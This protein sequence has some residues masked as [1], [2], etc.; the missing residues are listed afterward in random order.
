MSAPHLDH[1]S[2]TTLPVVMRLSQYS[3][4]AINRRR[5]SKRSPR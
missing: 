2:A 1:R 3:A 5:F 4:R